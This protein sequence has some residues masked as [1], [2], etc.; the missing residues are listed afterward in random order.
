[1][2][3][4]NALDFGS[5][6]AGQ[7]L[8][9]GGAGV[10]PSFTNAGSMALIQTQTASASSSIVFSTGITSTYLN[11]VL[12]YTNIVPSTTLTLE[13]Q[14]STNGG[15]TYITSGYQA[16]NNIT[17]YNSATFANQNGTTFFYLSQ[18]TFASFTS[19]FLYLNNLTANAVCSV[20]GQ[21][22]Q[23]G[24]FQGLSFGYNSGTTASNAFKI[25][26][27]TGNMT[28]GTFSLYALT[29]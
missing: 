23:D 17:S 22:Y 29:K 5:G 9:S 11:Y 8:T 4:N 28:S 27:S 6:T 19:G 20:N 1:M 21:F 26:T 12:F 3:Q 25:L 15:S 13:L 18:S 2:A 7:I 24:T 16:G 14:L 10:A